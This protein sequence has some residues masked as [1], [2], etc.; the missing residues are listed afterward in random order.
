MFRWHMSAR[1]SVDAEVWRGLTAPVVAASIA[2]APADTPTWSM[3]GVLACWRCRATCSALVGLPRF[4]LVSSLVGGTVR[5]AASPQTCWASQPSTSSIRQRSRFVPG[6]RQIG[7]SEAGLRV[8]SLRMLATD[9]CMYDASSSTVSN[10]FIG[11]I[12][13]RMPF[14]GN[15]PDKRDIDWVAYVDLL[16]WHHT[17]RL[18]SRGDKCL[19]FIGHV[20]AMCYKTSYRQ[21]IAVSSSAR[22]LA[23]T[24][25]A[26]NLPHI[27]RKNMH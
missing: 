11:N 6:S 4:G 17:L 18:S 23:V 5:V 15:G 20:F 26:T 3:P 25:L 1:R 2:Y 12:S 24:T 9:L 27:H 13:F 19:L 10:G 22:P 14:V 16:R 8:A 21:S 7:G